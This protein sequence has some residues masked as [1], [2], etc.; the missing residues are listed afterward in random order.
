MPY[1][2]MPI[3][4]FLLVLKHCLLMISLWTCAKRTEQMR[5]FQDFVGISEMK[6]LKHIQLVGFLLTSL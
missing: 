5:E 4:V 1:A 6:I 2:T 3:S